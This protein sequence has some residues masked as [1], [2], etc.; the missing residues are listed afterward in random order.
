MPK[1]RIIGAVIG[2]KYLGTIEA[3]DAEAAKELAPKCL[4]I[5]VSLCHECSRSMSDLEIEEIYRRGGP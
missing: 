5:G 4:D 1:Y 3:P 2:S